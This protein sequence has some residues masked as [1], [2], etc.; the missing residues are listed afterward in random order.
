MEQDG[1]KTGEERKIS[2][3]LK[4]RFPVPSCPVF[5]PVISRLPGL[6]GTPLFCK[7]MEAAM[8]K[9]SVKKL[10]EC[11][12]CWGA[13]PQCTWPLAEGPQVRGG[14]VRRTRTGFSQFVQATCEPFK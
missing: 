2:G 8:M 12:I 10:R 7:A 3:N 6:R 9:G 11:G 1:E 14:M 13:D 5:R 4:N